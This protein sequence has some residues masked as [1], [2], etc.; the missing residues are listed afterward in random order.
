MIIVHGSIPIVPERRE[1]ALE[2]AR[3]MSD[4]TQLEQGCISYDFYVG[5]Q[6]P[7][8]LV[9]FQEWETMEALMRHYQ[10]EHMKLFMD[11]LPEV[12]SGEINTR[13]YVVQTMD[14]NA[15]EPEEKYASKSE[16]PRIVQ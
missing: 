12:V 10:T 2:L 16:A 13:R 4:A 3:E 8:T 9:L 6:H 11:A 15:N 5:L 1:Q 14:A 7:N